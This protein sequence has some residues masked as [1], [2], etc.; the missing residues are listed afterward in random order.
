VCFIKPPDA[1]FMDCG[2][3]GICYSCAIDIWSTTD[4][5]YMCRHR[6]TKILQLDL[7]ESNNDVYKVITATLLVGSNDSSF[8]ANKNKLNANQPPP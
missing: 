8:E 6:I 1:V 2:H 3:G 4:D 5:C 7:K